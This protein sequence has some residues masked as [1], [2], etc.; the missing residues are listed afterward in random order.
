MLGV[1]RGDILRSGLLV[2]EMVIMS[3]YL[4]FAASLQEVSMSLLAYHLRVVLTLCLAKQ[5]V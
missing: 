1:N 4:V 5:G 3:G 2:A